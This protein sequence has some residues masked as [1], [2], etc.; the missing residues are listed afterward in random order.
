MRS[1]FSSKSTRFWRIP[2]DAQ[3]GGG[4]CREENRPEVESVSKAKEPAFVQADGERVWTGPYVKGREGRLNE[5]RGKS[6]SFK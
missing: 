4:G 1:R 2:V 5:N 6:R 3:F